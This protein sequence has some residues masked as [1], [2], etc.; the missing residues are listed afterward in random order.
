[1]P[2]ADEQESPTVKTRS[3]RAQ[4]QKQGATAPAGRPKRRDPISTK[5]SVT[6][7]R[8]QVVVTTVSSDPDAS[9]RK[10]VTFSDKD[11]AVGREG[12]QDRESDYDGGSDSAEGH[13][14]V[15]E[16]PIGRVMK[17]RRTDKP[18]M[19]SRGGGRKPVAKK[20]RRVAEQQPDSGAE[21]GEDV[22]EVDFEGATHARMSQ[23]QAEGEVVVAKDQG[24]VVRRIVHGSRPSTGPRRVE[25]PPELEV[26]MEGLL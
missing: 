18:S 4:E 2:S 10:A 23:Q 16:R 8:D 19:S 6:S 3:Q 9:S 21:S 25:E 26:E 17:A 20:R 14:Q 7:V 5:I 22:D 13:A 1:M 11:Q 12:F 24:P 15:E